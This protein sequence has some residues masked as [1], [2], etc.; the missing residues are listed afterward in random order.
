MDEAETDSYLVNV[1]LIA[2]QTSRPTL[3]L[4]KGSPA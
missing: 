4:S 3:E 2:V 1:R